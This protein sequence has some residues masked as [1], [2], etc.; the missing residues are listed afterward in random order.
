MA[1]TLSLGIEGAGSTYSLSTTQSMLLNYNM[2][3][4]NLSA[5]EAD[6][7]TVSVVDNIDLMLYAG[8][9][10]ALMDVYEDIERYL[11]YARQRQATGNA[12]RVFIYLQLD[13]EDSYRSEILSGFLRPGGDAFV[14]FVGMKMPVTLVVERRGYWEGST[15]GTA[16]SSTA[17]TNIGNDNY[18]DINSTAVKGSLPTPA[19]VDIENDTGAA[20]YYKRIWI[21]NNA[22]NDPANF[23]GYLAAADFDASGAT[24][25]FT[26]DGTYEDFI[27]LSDAFL[28]DTAGA[29]F[30]I[31]ASVT[32]DP[33]VGQYW[34]ALI[35]Y[36]ELFESVIGGEIYNL[37]DGIND[38]GVLP[39]PPGGYGAGNADFQLYLSVRHTVTDSATFSFI[40]LAPADNMRYLYQLGFGVPDG[41]SVVDKGDEGLAYIEEGASRYPILVPRGKPVMLWPGK[42]NR[43][44]VLMDGT[45]YSTAWASN[46]TVTY[47][48]RK[49]TL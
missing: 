20:R 8:T 36:G 7:E 13:G 23:T 49:V 42:T 48:P 39:F 17:I 15:P 46:V 4:A 18:V 2:T 28:T 9:T 38:F 32:N 44:H 43:L 5:V 14:A 45:G 19:I 37:H 24:I 11:A 6:P 30:R 41:A 31:L 1:H 22:F 10:A 3:P 21:W 34:K 12:E 16:K 40:Q 27:T 33:T 26:D 35:K 29:N 47:R 25:S